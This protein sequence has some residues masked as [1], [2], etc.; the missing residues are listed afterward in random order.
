M[1]NEIKPVSPYTLWVLVMNAGK[2]IPDS[3]FAWDQVTTALKRAEELDRSPDYDAVRVVKIA[4]DK[5]GE[6]KEVW[7]SSRLA[8]RAE[9]A[10]ANQLS[11]A[12]AQSAAKFAPKKAPT[13]PR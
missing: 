10:R 3:K 7:A 13:A 1:P 8:A 2:W 5:P 12:V 11:A 4:T 6:Q 9:A